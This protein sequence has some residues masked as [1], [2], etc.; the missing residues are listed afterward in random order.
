[1]R[2]VLLTFLFATA[3][4]AFT[5]QPKTMKKT[6]ELSAF[7]SRRDF[8][9]AAAVLVTG[10]SL[11]SP[12]KVL[13]NTG[14]GASHGSS[15]FVDESQIFEP[16][17]MHTG[18]RIDVNSAFIVSHSLQN[19]IEVLVS[20]LTRTHS[21]TRPSLDVLQDSYKAFPGFFPHAAGKVASH[22][23]YVSVSDI[24]KIPGLTEHDKAIFRKYDKYLTA[25]PPGRSLSERINSR[26]ST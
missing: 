22:G 18:N 11:F 25:N 9:G 19:Q 21:P 10:A 17:Q 20:I 3:A 6:T 24:Y 2:V 7:S 14:D 23:P 12:Q 15:F 26:V 5:L 8:L 13:A 1:M 16:A 4:N